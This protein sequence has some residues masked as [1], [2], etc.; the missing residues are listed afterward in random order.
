MPYTYLAY[1][2]WIG[3]WRYSRQTGSQFPPSFEATWMLNCHK[4]A[5]G[6]LIQ[7]LGKEK[8]NLFHCT[9]DGCAV[10]AGT[11][12]GHKR[13]ADSE[14]RLPPPVWLHSFQKPPSVSWETHIHL[15]KC[16]GKIEWGRWLGKLSTCRN[17]SI[18]HT[19][20]RNISET[21][22]LQMSQRKIQNKKTQHGQGWDLFFNNAYNAQI[23]NGSRGLI[24]H[25]TEM[26][27]VTPQF[28]KYKA[29]T[30]GEEW[31]L[32]T[33]L[34]VIKQNFPC[35]GGIHV[36]GWHKCYMRILS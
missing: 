11:R 34:K 16:G 19:V 30:Q 14:R 27:T 13:R 25:W 24:L 28:I 8:P 35:F 1:L 31:D 4:M 22:C 3:T 9:L 29:D 10:L 12:L 7:C 18:W 21:C 26:H 2:L 20:G 6:N 36:L 23:S 5:L 15:T 32:Q 33:L 17:W